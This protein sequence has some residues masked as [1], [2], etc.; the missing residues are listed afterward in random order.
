MRLTASLA[1]LSL[2]SG[3]ATATP[4]PLTRRASVA[5]WDLSNLTI[6][7]VRAPPVSWPLP[8]L[9]KDWD[10][11]NVGYDLNATVDYGVEL[12]GQAAKEGAKVVAFPE[13]WVPGYPKGY[14]QN[15][16]MLKHVD[17][18]I[19][20]SL[21]VNSTQWQQFV[22]AAKSNEVYVAL[23]FSERAGDHIYMAQALLGP[24]GETLIHRHKLRPSGSER[25][26]WSDGTIE[27]LQVVSSPIGRISLLECWEHFHPAM[28]FPIQA[29]SPDLHIGPFPY[30]PQIN[31]TSALWFEDVEV[32]L[33]AARVFAINSGAVT[34]TPG[35]GGAAIFAGTGSKLVEAQAND[36][37]EDEPIIYASVNA[38]AFAN[39]TYNSNGEQS[40]G[41]V[42]QIEA[43]IPD[44]IPREN[45]TLVPHRNTSIAAL[46]AAAANYSS[47]ATSTSSTASTPAATGT[48][49]VAAVQSGATSGA[50]SPLIARGAFAGLSLIVGGMLLA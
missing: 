33:A 1:V 5:D 20:N 2:L 45:G 17:S 37:F 43:A 3:F 31:D 48:G 27:E 41:I 26:L 15:D 36:S 40:W 46:E 19:E 12:I 16:W 50:S 32:N 10:A 13:T 22:N 24:D 28:T 38:T 7:A 4:S 49:A 8:I 14:D 9:N 11:S 25:D 29:Q 21:V 30:N 35:V 47:S 39:V 34:I 44:Y 42:K 18:Y 23:G 6:A